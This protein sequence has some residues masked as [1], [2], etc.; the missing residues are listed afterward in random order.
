MFDQSFSAKNFYNILIYE[1]RKGRN[2]EKEFF[3][4]EIFVKYS[5]RIKEINKKLKRDIKEFTKQDIKN[6]KPSPELYRRYKK[7]LQNKKL[8]LEHEKEKSLLKLLENISQEVQKSY[9]KFNLI[10]KTCNEK[11]IFTLDGK[12]E[13]FFAM[14]QLQY[15][16]QKLYGIK[17]A[18]RFEI[19]NQVKCLLN[20][21]FPKFIIKTDIKGFYENI[22]NT[23]IIEQLNTDNL[24]SPMSKKFIKQI[25]RNYETTAGVTKGNG[26]PRGIGISAYLA[27][28]FMRKI[29]EKI[30]NL[31]HLT[32]YSRYVDDILTIFTPKYSYDDTSIFLKKV[33]EIIESEYQLN[34]NT[35]KTNEIDLTSSC[36]SIKV[37]GNNIPS[38]YKLNYLGY[39]FEL[40]NSN[41]K[42]QI[43]ELDIY[44]TDEKITRYKEKIKKSF[45]LYNLYKDKN[46]GYRHLKN[47]IKFLTGNTRLINN[48]NNV[49]VGIYFSNMLLTKPDN[50]LEDLD[51]CLQEHIILYVKK[52]SHKDALL[53]LN[54]LKG[55][56]EKQFYVFKKQQFEQIVKAWKLI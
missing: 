50:A 56:K 16:F 15:N 26:I 9:F 3:E 14:K 40:N 38:P 44:L 49:L 7:I 52:D 45:E 12:P 32:Y 10:P 31:P 30:N 24:L 6:R 37:D 43:N 20:D 8:Q 17:Q 47:R 18:N 29:D 2:L 4:Q 55:F 48:K 36:N 1:N 19:V 41:K 27:E 54:F 42:G 46:K 51:K 53:K 33:K 23:R 21:K 28:Y 13:T 22:P 39:S 5:L 25:L 34:L 11:R 35:G